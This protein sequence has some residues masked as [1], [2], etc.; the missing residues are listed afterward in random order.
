MVR[1]RCEGSQSGLTVSWTLFVRVSS[2]SLHILIWCSC[3]TGSTPSPAMG[4]ETQRV[5]TVVCQCLPD[6]P[7]VETPVCLSLTEVSVHHRAP[8]YH[9]EVTQTSVYL[10]S[11]GPL[12]CSHASYKHPL[13]YHHYFLIFKV[14]TNSVE[15]FKIG[16][17]EKRDPRL[18][19]EN[20]FDC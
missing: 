11:E 5:V 16:L 9:Q 4:K 2:L 17:L 14:N 3:S 20:I 12:S 19:S 6:S 10:Q 8:C 1:V 7:G 15:C 13:R 18:I